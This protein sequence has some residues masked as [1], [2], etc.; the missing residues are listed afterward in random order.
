MWPALRQRFPL[1][2]GLTEPA[3][4]DTATELVCKYRV[5]W[6]SGA[7]A[8]AAAAAAAAHGSPGGGGWAAHEEAV[9]AARQF[10]AVQ[11]A[12]MGLPAS[13]QQAGEQAS[14]PAVSGPAA[15]ADHTADHSVGSGGYGQ[16]RPYWARLA[17]NR[18]I[19]A[20]T[21]FQDVRQLDVDLGDSGI[22]FQPGDVLAVVP[23]QP[24]SAVGA[25]LRR[26]GW[27]P[28]AWVR[29]EALAGAAPAAA[30]AGGEGGGGDNGAARH[31]SDVL[32]SCTVR[33]AALVSGAL[34]INGASPR[35]F[36]FQVSWR[37]GPCVVHARGAA[38]HPHP[39][40]RGGAHLL[41][42]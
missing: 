10:D 11:A 28:E 17:A 23:A 13:Q 19:T 21:H 38:W 15:T 14:P 34:D 35:R 7:E 33:L 24:D 2:P 39:C 5:T 42:P 6:L 25:L 32:A 16:H 18:R 40:Q 1:P 22:A 20:P 37:S 26:C 31:P 41:L 27:D 36:F 30:A 3:P 4:D 9:A 12:A 29:V 8:E